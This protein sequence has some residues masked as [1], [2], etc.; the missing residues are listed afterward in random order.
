MLRRRMFTTAAKAAAAAPAAAGA[1][2]SLAGKPTLLKSAAIFGSANALGFGISA[3]TGSHLHLDLIGTGVFAVAAVAT[4]GADARQRCSAGAVALWAVKLSS[5]LFYRALQTQHDGRLTEILSTTSGA[6]GFWFISFA[7]GWVVSLPHTIAAGVPAA[8][9]PRFGGPLDML[10]LGLFAAGLLTETAAD[11]TKWCFKADPANRGRF[12]DAGIWAASQHPNWFGNLALWS[13]IFLLN[14]PTLA[15]D[16]PAGAGWL[17]RGARLLGGAASPLFLLSLFYGQ[18]TDA[19]ANQAELARRRYASD[20]SYAAY[21]QRTPLVVP[22]I[23][24]LGRLFG[25]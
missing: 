9:R 22:T 1:A 15:A 21:E 6:A 24:S 8:G 7:W 23:A 16:L 2:A 12:C 20:P 5:F 17:R 14:V 19:I 11:Y 4:A 3:A 13:G 25:R 18:A 10:G